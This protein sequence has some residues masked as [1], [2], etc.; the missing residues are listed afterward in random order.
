MRRQRLADAIHSHFKRTSSDRT[1][2]PSPAL[3]EGLRLAENIQ[4]NRGK[5]LWMSITISFLA[6]ISLPEKT[7]DGAAV[8]T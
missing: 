8:P 6:A 2:E 1:K 5:V 7:A 3:G 4:E